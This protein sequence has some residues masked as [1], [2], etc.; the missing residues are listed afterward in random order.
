MWFA[1]IRPIGL[2][3]R[4]VPVGVRGTCRLSLFG[5]GLALLVGATPA[6]AL[7][8]PLGSIGFEL[9]VAD[10]PDPS[11]DPVWSDAY[12]GTPSSDENKDALTWGDGSWSNADVLLEWSGVEGDLDPFV[13]GNWAITNT[14]G[15]TQF[16][17]LIVDLPVAPVLPTSLM[18]GS[19]SITVS[20]ADGS[21]SATLA[22]VG[23]SA[24]YDGR[25]DFAAVV[26]A[27][28]LFGPGYSL[29]AG[30]LGTNSA[31]QTF[32]VPPGSVPGPGVTTAIGIQH[33]FSLTAGD[34]ATFNSIFSVV[35]PEPTP[36]LLLGVGLVGLAI[37]GR[38]KRQQ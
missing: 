31:T 1:E 21:G 8:I 5:A 24:L 22:S 20:D 13:S 25:I 9:Y 16:F 38:R 32:G 14:S 37:A 33:F 10:S 23:A 27:T 29:V 7:E 19:S 11:P 30:F 12:V 2:R 34:R 15:V 28:D 6:A 3:T 4:R 17:T 26:P 18:Y 35:V 36:L